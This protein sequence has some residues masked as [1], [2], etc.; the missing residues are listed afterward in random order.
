VG[1]GAG[2][3][4]AAGGIDQHGGGALDIPAD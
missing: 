3:A 2:D 4:I 1:I